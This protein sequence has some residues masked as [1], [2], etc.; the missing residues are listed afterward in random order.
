MAEGVFVRPLGNIVVIIPPLAIR[1]EELD[2]ICAAIER[3][4][5]KATAE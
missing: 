5:E 4:I 2:R 1:L 3:G